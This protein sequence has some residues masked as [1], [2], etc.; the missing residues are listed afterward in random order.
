MTVQELI[1]ELKKRD[2]QAEVEAECAQ[3][4]YCTT[5]DQVEAKGRRYPNTVVIR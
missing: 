5:V 4:D 2:P 3:C 1:E